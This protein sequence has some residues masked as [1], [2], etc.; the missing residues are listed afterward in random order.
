M[1]MN[2]SGR[3][4]SVD[5]P[6]TVAGDTGTPTPPSGD[7]LAWEVLSREALEAHDANTAGEAAVLWRRAALIAAGFAADDRRRAA[8]LGNKA[9]AGAF[10][11]DLECAEVGL[12]AALEAWGDTASWIGGMRVRGTA[13]SSLFHHRLEVR[14]RD[15]FEAHIRARYGRWIDGGLGASLFNHGI[16]LVSMDRDEAGRAQ[17]ARAVECRRNAFGGAD[18]ALAFILRTLAGLCPDEAEAEACLDRAGAAMTDPSPDGLERWQRDR[19][20]QLDDVRRLLSAVC[21]TAIFAE[22]DFL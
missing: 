1:T 14:H 4:I 13:R 19:P 10:D 11:D 6:S 7:E 2:M 20:P 18:P 15:N 12:R 8:S 21:L 3:L 22:R 16:I 17:L 5:N 9:M